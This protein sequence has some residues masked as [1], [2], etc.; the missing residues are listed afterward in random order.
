MTNYQLTIGYQMANYLPT[1][2]RPQAFLFIQFEDSTVLLKVT[3]SA[4]QDW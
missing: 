4:A 1:E 3:D 2:M